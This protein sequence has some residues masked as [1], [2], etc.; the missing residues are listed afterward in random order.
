MSLHSKVTTRYLA[1]LR[2]T[3]K[4]DPVVDEAR[5][6]WWRDVAVRYLDGMIRNYT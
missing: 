2:G 3:Y 1:I 5:K 6:E 4:W